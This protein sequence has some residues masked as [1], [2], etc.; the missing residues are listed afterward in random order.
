MAP[1]QPNI[2]SRRTI[3][4]N[5]PPDLLIWPETSYPYGWF[6]TSPDFPIENAPED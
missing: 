3:N 5:P 6:D 1:F 4:H 2:D